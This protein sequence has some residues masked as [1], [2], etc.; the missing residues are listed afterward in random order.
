[1]P[2]VLAPGVRRITWQ[3]A[4]SLQH[5]QGWVRPWRPPYKE[6]KL[7]PDELVEAQAFP[8]GVRIAF[9]SDMLSATEHVVPDANAAHIDLCCDGSWCQSI[10]LGGTDRF[11]FESLPEGEKLVEMRL[12]HHG[13]FLLRSLELSDGATVE[14][15][16]DM[17]PRWITYG[18]SITFCAE[19]G[20]PARTWPAIVAQ[21]RGLYLTCLGYGAQC[22]LD[23]MI[24]RMIR[25]L[26]ADFISMKLRVSIGNHASLSPRTFRPATIGTIQTIRERR[27]E[28]P[29]AVLS[30]ICCV[31]AETAPST[32]GFDLRMM[33]EEVRAA[34]ASVKAH[35][36]R[37]VGYFDG[38]DVLGPDRVNVLPDDVHPHAAGYKVLAHNSNGGAIHNGVELNDLVGA[39]KSR[40]QDYMEP[41]PHTCLFPV[42]QT[43]PAGQSGSVS[44]LLRKHL[45]R[46]IALQDDEHGR[47]CRSAVDR[48]A[49][50]R[51]T[52]SWRRKERLDVWP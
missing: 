27:P 38:L 25:D 39:P 42:A 6:S 1:M 13:A 23:P 40:K 30:S 31:P 37:N 2:R 11:C 9:R 35:G 21:N 52:P 18:S 47:E 12:H 19:A 50:R 14:R 4:V 26:P 29:M 3:G 49:I 7:L 44:H 36:D 45:P 15:F 20:S 24:V 32:V 5:T 16:E 46:D 41:L 48:L 51:P 34:V 22:H 8:A 17:R 28:V 33:R 10:S 43:S